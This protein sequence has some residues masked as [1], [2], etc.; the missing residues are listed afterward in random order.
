MG[1]PCDYYTNEV[2][3]MWGLEDIAIEAALT[4]YGHWKTQAGLVYEPI[5]ILDLVAIQDYV[6]HQA[7]QP[8]LHPPSIIIWTI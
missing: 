7:V 4:N 8:P 5:S 6:G 1:I 3:A 2:G